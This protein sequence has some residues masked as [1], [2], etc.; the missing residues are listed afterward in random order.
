MN[1][2][3]E[4]HPH[5]VR[6]TLAALLVWESLKVGARLLGRALDLVVP[7]PPP[8]VE[9]E[10]RKDVN[11]QPRRQAAAHQ[12]W[13]AAMVALALLSSM[14]AALGFLFIFWNGASHVLLGVTLAICFG[15]LG[16][17]LVVCARWLMPDMQ[18]IEARERLSSPPEEAELAKA[19]FYEGADEIPRRRLLGF[20]ALGSLAFIGAIA[21]SIFRSLGRAPTSALFAPVWKRG[22]ALVREDG[23]TVSLDTLEPGSTTIVFPPEKIGDER[24]QTV[25]LRVDESR[26]PQNSRAAWAPHGYYAYSRVCTHAGCAVGLFEVTTCLLVCPCHQSTFDILRG[27]QPTGG[28]AARPLPQ[29]PLYADADG[30]LRAGG[31][32]TAPPGPG[33][34]GMPPSPPSGGTE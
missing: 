23:T 25:L 17:A 15:G 7:S 13:G 19:N 11:L 14:F 32:F 28:P 6:L 22:Q 20:M 21:V 16:V 1:E 9:T 5:S 12:R 3:P 10:R 8:A 26:V 33:F 2:A 30:S 34:W 18:A 24:S 29:L 31:D 4:R 27:A